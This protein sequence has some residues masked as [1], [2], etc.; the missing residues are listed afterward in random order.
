[1]DTGELHWL[2]PRLREQIRSRRTLDSKLPADKTSLAGQRA[3]LG[4]LNRNSY[5][6]LA[7]EETERLYA[8]RGIEV[9]SPL[10]TAA[11]VQFA[12]SM[13]ARMRFRGNQNRFVH[14]RALQAVLPQAILE[15]QD[16]AEF[17]LVFRQPLDAMG[18]AFFDGVAARNPDWVVRKGVAR[19]VRAYQSNPCTGWSIWL[20]WGLFGCDSVTRGTKWP[21][22]TD[23][24][25]VT[26]SWGR[27][28]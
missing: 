16:K 12:M 4:L 1:M 21:F 10:N 20:L 5:R 14:V 23:H 26:L 7:I 6:D 8:A 22:Q 17:D 3:L 18:S 24:N 15:R 19:L 9:R 25:D 2:A 11:L 13:P 28:K 27:G